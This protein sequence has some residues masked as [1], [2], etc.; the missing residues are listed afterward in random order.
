VAFDED[1]K[2][3]DLLYPFDYSITGKANDQSSIVLKKILPFKTIEYSSGAELNGWKIPQAW[4]LNYLKIYENGKVLFEFKD[5]PFCVPKNTPS[6]D[7]DNLSLQELLGR[8][9]RS[10]TGE[11]DDFVYDWRNLYHDEPLEWS[12][13]LS[14]EMIGKLAHGN[15]Y[16]VVISSTFYDSTMKVLEFDTHPEITS[17]II[18]NAHNCHPFQANDDTSGIVAGIQL[19]KMWAKEL[20]PSFNL[21]LLIAPELYGPMFFLDSLSENREFLGVLLFK[22]IGNR[23][24]LKLQQSVQENQAISRIASRLFHEKGKSDDVYPFRTL[25]GND[26][27]VFEAP[28]YSIPT[29]T[30]T[31]F[32][33][34]EY[35]NSSDTPARIESGSITETVEVALQLLLGIQGNRSYRWIS[36]GLPKLSDSH[37]ELYKRTEAHGINNQGISDV[38]SRWHL[39]MNS[40]PGL[41]HLGY[42]SVE[43]SEKFD[44][45]L[46][47]V[48]DYL[49]KWEAAGFIKDV[50]DNYR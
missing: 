47:E 18:V 31:R 35:H 13:S 14:E 7:V 22:S 24:V 36:K 5:H 23:G 28:P 4:K 21:K 25:H 38:E 44:L 46:L 19:A 8:L 16:R 2:L 50:K 42:D 33:F 6:I 20:T 32:P 30:L 1:K 45:P 43:F 37:L 41:V 26:E 3:L 10:K 17:T 9:N 29:V 39:L 40:L 49:T 27:I 48:I 12:L 34:R 15:V 11:T